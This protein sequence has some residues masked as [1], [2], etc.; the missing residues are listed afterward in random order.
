MWVLGVILAAGA[1]LLLGALFVDLSYKSGCEK[2]CYPYQKLEMTFDK[3]CVCS[4]PSH[5]PEK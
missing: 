3:G 5:R 4:S 1:F 2:Q